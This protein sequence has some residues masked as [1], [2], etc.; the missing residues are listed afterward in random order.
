MTQITKHAALVVTF[1]IM[2][3]GMLYLAARPNNST[4]FCDLTHQS[5]KIK[6]AEQGF[7]IAF[8]EPPKIE[9]QL[10]LNINSDQPFTLAK[11]TI[12]GI[13]MYMGIIPV[14]AESQPTLIH[15]QWQGWTLLGACS[16][17]NMIWQLTITVS[18]HGITETR[19]LRFETSA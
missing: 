13:N 2:V 6:I 19:R 4:Q 9:H 3:L 5:C 8:S 16:E 12:T 7:T 17:P 14:V 10:S 11:A 1:L 15:K 18:A